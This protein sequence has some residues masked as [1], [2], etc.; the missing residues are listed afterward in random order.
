MYDASQ[1]YYAEDPEYILTRGVMIRRI[2][3][4]FA[5]L[6]I[7]GLFALMIWGGVFAFGVITLGLGWSLFPV[8]PLIPFLYHIL[9]VASPMAATP[10]QAMFGLTVRNNLDLA[11]PNIIQ[12]LIYTVIFYATLAAGVIWLGIAL[13]T[14]RHRTIHDLLSGLVVV[15]SRA[16]TALQG[17]VIMPPPTRPY[18]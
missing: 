18:A 6:F 4:W 10:G 11:R 3:A 13:F 16:L 14:D 9:F 8:L 2:F 7:L 1:P 5:D 15:R 12:A 17:P